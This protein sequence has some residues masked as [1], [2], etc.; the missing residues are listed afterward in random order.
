[1]KTHGLLA[2][3][4]LS[5]LLMLRAIGAPAAIENGYSWTIVCVDCPHSFSRGRMTDRALQIDALGQP[6]VAYG[7]G[8]LY[9]AV[10]SDN[11]HGGAGPGSCG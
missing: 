9:Y 2:T 5:M 7:G 4:A 10:R 8:Q 3:L 1:M 11:G 6:H